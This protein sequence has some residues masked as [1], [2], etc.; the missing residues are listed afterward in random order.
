MKRSCFRVVAFAL[1]IVLSCFAFGASAQNSNGSLSGMVTDL[2]GIALPHAKVRVTQTSD[3]RNNFET[4][5]DDQGKFHL[6]NLPSG[7]YQVSVTRQDSASTKQQAVTVPRGRTVEMEIRFSAGCDDV[8][9]GTATDEDK[10]EVIKAT[11]AEVA[12]SRS[13]LIEQT[14]REKGAVLSTQNIQRDWV[15]ELPGLSVQLLT[16]AEIQHKANTQGDFL[17]LSIPEVKVRHQCIAVTVTNSWAVGT[18]SRSVYL[19]GGG[20]SYE[21]RKQSGRWVGK[22]VSGWIS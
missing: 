13:D 2:M 19:S 4:K 18:R 7:R 14:Q 3:R 9:E 16:P 1:S 21:Y 12:S 5:T 11:L 22:L 8:A 17:F 20:A 10:A 15:R 6:A